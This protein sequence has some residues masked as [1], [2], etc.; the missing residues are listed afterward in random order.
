MRVLNISRFLWPKTNLLSKFEQFL[1][2]FTGRYWR[3]KDR[4]QIDTLWTNNVPS[5]LKRTNMMDIFNW[6]G[7]S[8]FSTSARV[9][10][11]PSLPASS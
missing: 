10:G 1:I 7:M 4:A 8:F 3:N 11:L 9:Q 6:E 2:T 5:C